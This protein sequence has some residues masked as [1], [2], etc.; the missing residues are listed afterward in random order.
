MELG[1]REKPVLGC[2]HFRAFRPGFDLWHTRHVIRHGHF[3]LKQLRLPVLNEMRTNSHTDPI[4]YFVIAS[5]HVI[6]INLYEGRTK[7]R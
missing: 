5:W 4:D 7:K 3:A 2:G 1:T 6:F